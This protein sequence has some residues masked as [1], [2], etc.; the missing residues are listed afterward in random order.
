VH[1]STSSLAIRI[2]RSVIEAGA[3]DGLGSS[4]VGG[5][6]GAATV[7]LGAV[8]AYILAERSR[9][10]DRDVHDARK[11]EEVRRAA[12]AE[13]MVALSNVR[14]D[15]CSHTNGLAGSASMWPLRNA[16]FTTHVPLHIF[17]TYWEVKA[18]YDTGIRWR[19]WV[20]DTQPVMKP[21][22]LEQRYPVVNDYRE[23]LRGY[24]DQVISLLQDH[25]E[26]ATLRFSRPE[27]PKLPDVP[28]PDTSVLE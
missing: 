28:A 16:L 5:L 13:L 1:T 27:L 25:L 21:F 11:A 7:A 8:L 3:W 22:E 24:G 15:V 17:P 6:I 19:Q 12:A 23:A 26:D 18:F 14:D 9:R 2:V 4:I 20:R 10:S